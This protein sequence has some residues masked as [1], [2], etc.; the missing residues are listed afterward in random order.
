MLPFLFDI[1]I[2]HYTV[3]K[4]I[5]M[6]GNFMNVEDKARAA[7]SSYK[8]YVSN[9]A[10]VKEELQDKSIDLNERWA[11]FMYLCSEEFLDC[12]EGAWG[13]ID[14]LKG[15]NGESINLEMVMGRPIHTMEIVS[16]YNVYKN[17]NIMNEDS[18]RPTVSEDSLFEWKEK[19]LSVGCS[20]FVLEY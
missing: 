19:I 11:A 13:Y 7:V 20:D 17:I 1:F 8:S 18:S 5:V 9:M 3:V 15:T 2:E 4:M 14:I 12:D 10:M 6:K 16:Y